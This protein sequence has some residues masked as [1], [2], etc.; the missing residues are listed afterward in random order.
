MV[1][2]APVFENGS[3]FI[4][5]AINSLSNNVVNLSLNFVSKVNIKNNNGKIPDNKLNWSYS[6]FE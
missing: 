1:H 2:C 4:P 5:K 6:I 3:F